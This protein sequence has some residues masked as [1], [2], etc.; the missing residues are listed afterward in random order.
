MTISILRWI[1]GALLLA[2]LLVGCDVSPSTPNRTAGPAAQPTNVMT[3][4]PGSNQGGAYPPP[5]SG[6]NYPPPGPVTAY[7]GPQEQAAPTANP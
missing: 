4:Q 6:A 2:G 3:S 5:T 1:F 7:P